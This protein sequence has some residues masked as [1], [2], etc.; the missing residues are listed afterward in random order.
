MALLLS[1]RKCLKDVK[2]KNREQVQDLF[3]NNIKVVKYHA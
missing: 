3:V 2:F 1:L